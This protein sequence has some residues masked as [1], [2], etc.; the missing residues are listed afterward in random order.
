MHDGNLSIA[1]FTLDNKL[2][3]MKLL[4]LILLSA[5][6]IVS[7][8]ATAPA[9]NTSA[10]EVIGAEFDFG[11]L[12]YGI[13]LLQRIKIINHSDSLLRITKLIP[14]CGCTRMVPNRWE[15]QSGESLAF[16]LFLDTKKIGRGH[17]QK[18]PTIYTNSAA[19]QRIE[20]KMTGVAANPGDYAL[21]VELSPNEIVVHRNASNS[22]PVSIKNVSKD[23]LTIKLAAYTLDPNIMITLPPTQ[24]TAGRTELIKVEINENRLPAI[25]SDSFTICLNDNRKT[26]ITVPI[27]W[28]D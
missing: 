5:I 8:Q 28:E 13:T 20:T 7:I 16:D 2:T 3:L 22:I 17:F 19:G 4:R 15:A 27:R 26:R 9:A 18:S 10:I 21:P 1:N 12:P 11:Y 25:L 23:D 6:L 24:L 14:G